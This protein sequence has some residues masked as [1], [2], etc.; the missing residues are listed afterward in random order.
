MITVSP[1]HSAFEPSHI[2]H[3]ADSLKDYLPWALPPKE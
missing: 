3:K 1:R 2:F